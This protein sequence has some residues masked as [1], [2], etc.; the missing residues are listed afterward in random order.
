MK[1]DLVIARVRNTTGGYIF[2]TLFVREG[3]SHLHPI[4]PPF[5]NPCP[6][7]GTPS[8]SRNTSTGPMSFPGAT[9]VAGPRSLPG[10]YPSHRWRVPQS[11]MREVP[12]ST[13]S[14]TP[15]Q[16]RKGYP[17]GQVRMGYPRQVTLGRVMPQTVLLLQFPTGELSCQK[18][19]TNSAPMLQYHSV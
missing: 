3:V 19:V 7:W 11:Q 15:S 5:H 17:P 13:Q 12:K 14:G 6:L 9:P 1:I 18:I 10:G 16:D 8:P 4:I 2:S